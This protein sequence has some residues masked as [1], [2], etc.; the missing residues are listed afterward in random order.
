MHHSKLQGFSLIELLV[1]IAV[2]SVLA[3]LLLPAVQQ[4][5]EAARRSSCQSNLKQL[6]LALHNYHDVHGVF[7]SRAIGGRAGSNELKGCNEWWSAPS[8]YVGLMPFLEE[9]ALYDQW[10]AMVADSTKECWWTNAEWDGQK[11]QMRVLLCPSDP[12]IKSDRGS[13]VTNYGF[14][15]GDNRRQTDLV[16]QPRGV[17][18]YASNLSYKDILDGTSNTIAFA[19][20]MRPLADRQRGDTAISG[21]MNTEVDSPAAC[22]HPSIWHGTEYNPAVE[23]VGLADKHGIIALA[24]QPMWTAVVTGVAPNGPSC[25]PYNHYWEAG[26]MT[27]NSRHTGGVQV[28]MVDGSVRFISENIDSGNQWAPR[29]D[30]GPSPYGVWGA[31]GTRAEGEVIGEF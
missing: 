2:I 29:P 12:M 25:L 23:V 14:V 9:S 21:F 30:A 24:G 28:C 27:A 11:E 26:W 8:G 7:V 1:V 5:R 4:A 10:N 19:E 13:S 17:F 31:L 15:N 3:A 22:A 6:G 16:S 20:I 18:G